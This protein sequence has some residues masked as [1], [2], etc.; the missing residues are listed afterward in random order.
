MEWLPEENATDKTD[1]DGTKRV[2]KVTYNTDDMYDGLR[3]AG[4]FEYQWITN[5]IVN[6]HEN[7]YESNEE[8]FGWDRY[9]HIYDRLSATGG[10]VADEDA[11]MTILSEVGR[12]PHGGVTVH[13]VVYNLTEKTVLWVANENYTD[14]S[15]YYQYS[16]E[17][18]KLTQLS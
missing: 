6:D 2:L 9:Q 5:F 4:D 18:G 3:N 10:I 13:S 15:A 12:R 16:F 8:K 11:A 17:T 1:N 14:K 7:Y